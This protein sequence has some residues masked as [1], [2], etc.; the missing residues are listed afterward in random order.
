MLQIR[1]FAQSPVLQFRQMPIGSNPFMS[2]YHAPDDMLQ[3]LPPVYLMVSMLSRSLNRASACEL[4]A[5]KAI[6]KVKGMIW[7]SIAAFCLA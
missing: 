3:Q 2:P 6:A 5:V 1:H 4:S 7:K